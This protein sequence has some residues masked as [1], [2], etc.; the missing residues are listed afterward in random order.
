MTTYIRGR[1]IDIRSETEVLVTLEPEGK[2]TEGMELIVYEEGD[3]ITDSQGNLHG[4]FELQKARIRVTHVQPEAVFAESAETERIYV[5]PE[6][7]QQFDPSD[8]VDPDP[9]DPYWTF[10]LKRIAAVPA[11]AGEEGTAKEPPKE[12]PRTSRQLA[13]AQLKS[14]LVVV[15]DLVRS[16]LPVE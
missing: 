8:Y 2:A 11:E 5:G 16:V 9:E 3:P 1:I 6:W 12:Q 7:E 10:R 4:K 14:Q 13:R 15:G